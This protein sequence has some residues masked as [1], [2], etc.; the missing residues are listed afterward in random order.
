MSSS[1]HENLPP[2]KRLKEWSPFPSSDADSSF[3]LPSSAAQLLSQDDDP[4]ANEVRKE[5]KRLQCISDR[6][7][8]ENIVRNYATGATEDGFCRL[9]PMKPSK[10]G[11]YIQVSDGGANKFAT[12]QEVLI[13]AGGRDLT[14]G[15]QASHLCC[16]PSCTVI[17]HVIP[18]S[19]EE[20]NARKN[21]VVFGNCHHCSKKVLVCQHTPTCIKF[22]PGFASWQDFLRDGVCGKL[23]FG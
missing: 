2:P 11:G 4:D 18:E 9:S 1:D 17:E 21:C 5:A 3:R 12:L 23:T 14:G 10:A 7:I 13:W 19:A 22:C 6:T 15:A 20:N 16:R 8:A